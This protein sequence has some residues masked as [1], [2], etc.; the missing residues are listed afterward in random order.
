MRPNNSSA[1]LDSTVLGLYIETPKVSMLRF[2][3][4]CWGGFLGGFRGRFR[5][6]A[7]AQGMFRSGGS[8]ELLGQ[9]PERVPGRLQGRVPA[10]VRGRFGARACSN[11]TFVHTCVCRVLDGEVT[12]IHA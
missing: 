9:V 5:V 7:R 12:M 6:L 4:A 8:A 1:M 10:R 2:R 3:R 11:I